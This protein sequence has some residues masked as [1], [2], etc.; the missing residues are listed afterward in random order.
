M[1]TSKESK[2]SLSRK[3]EGKGKQRFAKGLNM[4]P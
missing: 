4:N 1:T 2:G 3:E